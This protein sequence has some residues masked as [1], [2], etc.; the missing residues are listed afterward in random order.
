[1]KF[2]PQCGS[3]IMNGINNCPNCGAVLNNLNQV[4]PAV[5]PVESNL[6]NDSI[7]AKQTLPNI[8]PPIVQ[9]KVIEQTEKQIP[10]KMEESNLDIKQP[11]ISDVKSESQPALSPEPITSMSKQEPI[12]VSG[13][14]EIETNV[15]KEDNKAHT[16][17]EKEKEFNKIVTITI[18]VISLVA[19]VVTSF[20]LIKIFSKSEE[21]SN[22]KVVVT[23]EYTYEGFNFFLPEG[24]VASVEKDEFVIRATDETWSAVITI[25]DGT[26]N[27]LVSNKEQISSYF[28]NYGYVVTPVEAKEVSGTSFL[29]TEVLMGSENV[30][31][32][33]AKAS[34]TKVYG[35]IYT[36][37]WNKS[38]KALLLVIFSE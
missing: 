13:K 18:I 37:D 1:M 11:I 22:E 34:G 6:I 27:T 8:E 16:P 38:K 21:T 29:T 28:E 5:T 24:I 9:P 2:C 30:L 36:N 4:Q 35:I 32:A 17:E 23:R 19:L 26:Y 12:V 10:S 33:Y 15:I 20:F 25:Q 31:V 7:V 3:T 14:S